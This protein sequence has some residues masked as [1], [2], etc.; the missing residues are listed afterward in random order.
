VGLIQDMTGGGDQGPMYFH[1]SRV[2]RG[3]KRGRLG[4][5]LGGNDQ[6]LQVEL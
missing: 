1:L 4:W 6:M 3:F 5:K 2:A